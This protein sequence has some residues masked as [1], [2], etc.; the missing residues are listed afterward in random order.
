MI[1]YLDASAIVKLYVVESGSDQVRQLT[2]KAEIVGTALISRAEV[3]VALAKAVRTR[4]LD[5]SQ[6]NAAAQLF[7]SQWLD[8]ARVQITETTISRAD[9]L[10]WAQRLGGYDAVHIASALVWQETIGEPV[11]L[12]TFDQQLH[13]A[14][15]R[16]GLNIWP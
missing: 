10:A 15:E 1:L 12:A 16:S 4:V 13:K 3:V 8:H 9:A 6:A 14:G 2:S 5:E 7:R 11:M